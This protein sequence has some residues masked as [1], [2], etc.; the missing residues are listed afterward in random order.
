MAANDIAVLPLLR[1]SLI[2]TPL[3][4]SHSA[5][6]KFFLSTKPEN[7]TKADFLPFGTDGLTF[8]DFLDI[9]NPLQHLPVIGSFY[10]QL[11]GDTLDPIPQIVGSTLFFGPIGGAAASANLVL[12]QAS[13]QTFNTHAMEFISKGRAVKTETEAS[14]NAINTIENSKIE[15]INEDLSNP[16]VV[17]AWAQSELSY[18]KRLS[19]TSK[20]LANTAIPPK[21]LATPP[22]RPSNQVASAKLTQIPLTEKHRHLIPETKTDP[23]RTDKYSGLKLTPTH[24]SLA[25]AAYKAALNRDGYD[26]S[27]PNEY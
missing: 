2:D 18:R 8:L 13:G 20:A 24:A 7:K 5:S 22:H 15:I 19:Q 9:V 4:H 26:L 14:E 1:G 17:S 21:P 11:T 27:L 25:A 12:E 10:R 3:A 6:E 23:G 16:S